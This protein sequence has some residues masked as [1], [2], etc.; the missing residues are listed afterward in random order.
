MTLGRVLG[1]DLG[2][3]FDSDDH[4]EFPRRGSPQLRRCQFGFVSVVPP[5]CH[6]SRLM[7]CAWGISMVNGVVFI[8]VSA[9]VYR[10]QSFSVV[11][12]DVGC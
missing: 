6:A 12:I 2:I 1:L 8:S 5:I 4:N 11:V 9:V 10:N 7:H 3:P